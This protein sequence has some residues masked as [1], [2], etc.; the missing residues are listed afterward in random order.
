MN[1]NS[2]WFLCL[3]VRLLI[4]LLLYY[5]NRNNSNLKNKKTIKN[6]SIIILFIIG[7]GFI[8]KGYFG[9]NNEIQISKVFWHRTRYIHGIIYILASS[10]LKYDNLNLCLL[11]LLLD[12]IFSVLYRFLLD[13]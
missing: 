5:F 6:F 1:I 10:Y 3:I 8:R 12:V 2:L 4:I 13:V 7:I 11:L 9:S